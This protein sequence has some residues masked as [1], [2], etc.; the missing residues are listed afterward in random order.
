[1]RG[2]VER[3]RG[4]ENVFNRKKTYT[5]ETNKVDFYNSDAVYRSGIYAQYIGPFSSKLSKWRC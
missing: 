3:R 1:M 2:D 4:K 5:N